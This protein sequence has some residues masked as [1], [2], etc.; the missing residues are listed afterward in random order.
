MSLYEVIVAMKNGAGVI[1]PVY[2]KFKMKNFI[3][4]DQHGDSIPVFEFELI[5]LTLKWMIDGN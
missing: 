1:H 3:V 2:G 5:S 4:T